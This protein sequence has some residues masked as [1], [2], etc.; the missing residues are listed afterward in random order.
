[1]PA[2]AAWAG[3]SSMFGALLGTVLHR[4]LMSRK[5]AVAVPDMRHH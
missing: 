5:V 3:F 4:G 1:M 2:L